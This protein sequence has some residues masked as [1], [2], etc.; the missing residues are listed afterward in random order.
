MNARLSQR[1][2]DRPLAKLYNHQPP[3][4]AD[5]QKQL[6]AD[7]QQNGDRLAL[8][9]LITTNARFVVD[10]VLKHWGHLP[11]EPAEMVAYGMEGLLRAAERYSP[12]H[13][14]NFLS[15]AIHW[16]KQS[17]LSG[18]R[19]GSGPIRV[20]ASQI[21]LLANYRHKRQEL[22]DRAG[23]RTASDQEIADALQWT[24]DQRK[25]FHSLQRGPQ[26]IDEPINHEGKTR[27]GTAK[28]RKGSWGERYLVDDNPPADEQLVK[29]ERRERVQDLISLLDD[30]EQRIVR[31]YYGF[32]ESDGEP[33][34]Q[35]AT[36]NGNGMTL[37]AIG[38]IEGLTRER[39]RQ[40]LERA[41]EKMR[42]AITV[43]GRALQGRMGTTG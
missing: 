24:T 2:E 12:D 13:G 41:K 6:V 25:I 33:N 27:G 8:E 21:Q 3:L 20:K 36:G 29:E 35:Q 38:E 14:T 16:V 34:Q 28:Q 31:R 19:D 37:E 5:E 39:V 26:S 15:Y 11:V 32:T 7:Y 30:R 43:N 10:H 4:P 1:P 18:V 23:G 42:H 22:D 40:L 17:V 9:K